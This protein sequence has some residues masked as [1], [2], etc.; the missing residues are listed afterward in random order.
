MDSQG[1]IITKGRKDILGE[2]ERQIAMEAIT[3]ENLEENQ[4]AKRQEAEKANHNATEAHEETAEK[5][6]QLRIILKA[7]GF[8][9]FKLIVKPVTNFLVLGLWHGSR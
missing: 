7:K 9:L 6:P 4:R 3:E 5:E 2:E 1:N 8:D